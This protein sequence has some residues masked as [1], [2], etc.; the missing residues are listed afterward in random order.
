MP[1][2][3]LIEGDNYHSLSVLN[4]TH[5]GKIDLIYLDPP[6]NTG[7]KDFRYNDKYVDDE[8]TYRHS[9]WISFM[10][11]RLKLTK[12]LLNQNGLI[13]I[14]IDH[15]ELA[16]LKLLLD[17]EIFGERNFVA[18]ITWKQ[19]HTVKNSAR[20][21]SNS[22]EYVLV[23]AKN[24]ASIKQ[25]R[26]PLEKGDNYPYDDNDGKGKYELESFVRQK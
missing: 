23:Y 17:T 20:Y 7:N 24:L 14:S 10:S 22:T 11:S 5:K 16:Q 15:N 3:I 9:K 26:Q 6:Y 12:S 25:I 1:N 21:F 19:L 2:H 8:D 18:C 13:F 4:Y